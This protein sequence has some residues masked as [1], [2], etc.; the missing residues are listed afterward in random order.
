MSSHHFMPIGVASQLMPLGSDFSHQ[1]RVLL[2]HPTYD[3]ECGFYLFLIKQLQQS[4]GICHDPVLKGRPAVPVRAT[5]RFEDMVPILNVEGEYIV[6]V[7]WQV[8]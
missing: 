1:I 3:E 8:D 2:G 7:A 4:F 5:V 6:G